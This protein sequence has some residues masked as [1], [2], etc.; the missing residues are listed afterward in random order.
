MNELSTMDIRDLSPEQLGGEIRLLT[1][2]ARRMALSYGIQ[3]GYRLHVAHEKVGPHGW[4]EWLKKET[5]FSAASA[6]RFESLYEGYGEDQGNLFGVGNKFPTLEKLSISNA[7]RLLAVPEEEREDVARELDA[8]HLSTRELDKALK[9]RDEALRQVKELEEQLAEAEDGHGLAITE[10]EE[11]IDELQDAATKGKAALKEKESI[12]NELDASNQQLEKARE[13]IEELR[14]QP[15]ATVVQRD[16]AAIEEAVTAA[17]AK[18]TQEYATQIQALQTALEKA[19]SKAEKLKAK[20][21]KADAAA[22]GKISAAEKEAEQLR[23][24]LE[25][26]RRKLQ[27]SDADVTAFGIH[28][29]AGQKELLEAFASLKKI[30]ER[31]MST[32]VKLTDAFRQLQNILSERIAGMEKRAETAE[33]E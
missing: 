5:E 28:F 14:S 23:L 24:D 18:V 8:E 1:E 31:D 21:D 20:A 29:N 13:E 19:N 11:K 33:E 10:L 9:E 4:A 22:E 15:A 30:A 27:L 3:I 16:E 26:A 6:S 25:A 32:A 7:L 17:K 12:L 2:Q